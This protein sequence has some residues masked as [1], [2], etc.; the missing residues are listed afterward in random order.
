MPHS[1]PKSAL[2]VTISVRWEGG[3]RTFHMALT[4]DAIL[5][6]SCGDA[7]LATS[8]HEKIKVSFEHWRK[9]EIQLTHIWNNGQSQVIYS[10]CSIKDHQKAQEEVVEMLSWWQQHAC[11]E[12]RSVR[13]MLLL[14]I[15]TAGVHMLPARPKLLSLNQGIQKS[16]SNIERSTS[17][18]EGTLLV[19]KACD[20]ENKESESETIFN[21]IIYSNA[22]PISR[23]S[24]A[25]EEEPE[26]HV[27]YD[28]AHGKWK[29]IVFSRT[30]S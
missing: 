21:T 11:M 6:S 3:D 17:S 10:H 23:D 5:A 2:E 4:H 12:P 25:V 7:L 29:R 18:P 26:T 19:S 30:S 24:T 20:T 9:L 27:S 14:D 16:S 28:R 8:L 22:T 1:I 15:D 13:M